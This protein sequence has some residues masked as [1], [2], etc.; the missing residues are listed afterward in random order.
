[1]K[2]RKKHYDDQDERPN[3][4]KRIIREVENEKEWLDEV[5]MEE[6]FEEEM[7]EDLAEEEY[8]DYE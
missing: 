8:D 3:R 4:K 6:D 2:R 1:M 7:N 5:E